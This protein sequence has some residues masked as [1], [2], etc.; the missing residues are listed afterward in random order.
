ML[1]SA[2]PAIAKGFAGQV[3]LLDLRGI[4]F[5]IYPE[6]C[7]QDQVSLRVPGRGGGASLGISVKSLVVEVSLH[8]GLPYNLSKDRFDLHESYQ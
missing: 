1:V 2:C 7:I 4:L 5:L 3:R 6:S 8:I